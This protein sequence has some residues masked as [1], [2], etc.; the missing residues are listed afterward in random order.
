MFKNL[1]GQRIPKVTFRTRKDHEWINLDSDDV[2]AGKSVVLFSLPG[3]FTP[4]CSSSHVP[5][6]NQLVPLFEANG[7]DEVICVSVNDAFVMNEWKR[8]QHADRVTFLPDGNGDFSDGMGLLVNKDDLGFGKRSWR[9][10]MLVRD[11]VIEKMFVEPEEPGDPFHVSDAD[12]MLKYLA[13]QGELPHDVAI[14]TR[15]GCPFCV[16]AKG[17]LRDAGIDFQELLLN[18]DY[19]DQA[20]RAVSSSTSYPQV[21]IDGKHIGGSDDLAEWLEKRQQ[22]RARTAA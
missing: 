19:T 13:P 22:S 20:L 12:T 17:L 16:R 15:D 11:G 8:S 21:F 6:Y 2:F 7:I 10:S 5:R 9:Y 3:A 18:R 1:E 4:T 14:F